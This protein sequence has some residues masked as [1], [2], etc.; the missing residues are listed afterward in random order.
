MGPEQDGRGH[1]LPGPFPKGLRCALRVPAS[2]T[3]TGWPRAPHGNQMRE[4]WVLGRP[5]KAKPPIR[6]G[7]VI[8]ELVLNRARFGGAHHSSLACTQITATYPHEPVRPFLLQAEVESGG[9]A[10]P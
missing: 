5:C 10:G 2:A 6:P 1:F 7:A 8:E 9:V 4:T 3:W